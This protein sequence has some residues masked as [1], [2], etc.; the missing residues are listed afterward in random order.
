MTW[1]NSRSI[2]VQ[3]RNHDNCLSVVVSN[4]VEERIL[5]DTSEQQYR[6][7]ACTLSAGLNITNPKRSQ[8]QYI[9]ACSLYVSNR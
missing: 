6:F 3:N 2:L 4:C 7:V 9:L 5:I 8:G 1:Q